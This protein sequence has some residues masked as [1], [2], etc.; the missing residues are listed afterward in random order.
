MEERDQDR[1]RVVQRA[2]DVRQR[3]LFDLADALESAVAV[4]GHSLETENAFESVADAVEGE[5]VIRGVKLLGLRSRNRR[6][7]DTP[8]V[9]GGAKGLLEGAL[10]YIDHPEDASK[11]RSYRDKFGVV[12]SVEYRAGQGHFGN[13]RYNPRHECAEQFLWDVRNSPQSLGMSINAKFRPGGTDKSGDILVESLEVVRSVDIVTKPAT[14]QGIFEHEE[15]DEDMV[16]DVK[17]LKEKHPDVVEQLLAESREA[18]Q[19]Q[20]E[21]D[22]LRKE[23]KEAQEQLAAIKAEKEAAELWSAVEQSLKPILVGDAAAL[24]KDAV[25]CACQMQDETRKKFTEFVGK[26]GPM[27]QVVPDSE[28]GDEPPI[29]QPVEEQEVEEPAYKPSGARGGKYN[30]R[31]SV[32]LK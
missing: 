28:D 2:A 26:L 3:E 13:I 1:P 9:R 7:Y 24:L 12:E 19:E 8:G 32:G 23:A 20:A 17:T 29:E 18:G 5:N 16:I 25:E 6:N 15:E 10:V 27:L 11:P 22:R 14:A 30:F 4:Q 31:A 21:I